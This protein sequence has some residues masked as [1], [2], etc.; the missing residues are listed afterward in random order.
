[1]ANLLLR[2]VSK[3]LHTKTVTTQIYALLLKKGISASGIDMPWL[4][5]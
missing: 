2:L 5:L 4:H 1:M 3:D